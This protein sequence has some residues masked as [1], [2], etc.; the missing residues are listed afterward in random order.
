MSR[1]AEFGFSCVVDHQVV[2]RHR[3]HSTAREVGGFLGKAAA[4]ENA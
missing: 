3:Y 4:A 1:S 2:I